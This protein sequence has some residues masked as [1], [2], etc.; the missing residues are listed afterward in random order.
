MKLVVII[1]PLAAAANFADCYRICSARRNHLTKSSFPRP[2]PRMSSFLSSG[3]AS[4]VS[5]VFGKKGSCVQR[6]AR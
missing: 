5:L 1:Q 2:M 6:T 4:P 3:L